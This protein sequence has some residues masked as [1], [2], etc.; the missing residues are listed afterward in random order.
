MRGLNKVSLI[1]HLD[2]TPE[3]RVLSGG[4]S[5]PSFSLATT[6]IYKDKAGFLQMETEWHSVVA[7]RNL[8]DLAAKYLSIFGR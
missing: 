3:L 6:E 2:K 4:L 7:W 5:V 1:G 8:A